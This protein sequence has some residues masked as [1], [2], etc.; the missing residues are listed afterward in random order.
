MESPFGISLRNDI[1]GS[2]GGEVFFA[3]DLDNLSEAIAAGGIDAEKT[4]YLIGIRTP[5]QQALAK[6]IDRILESEVIWD[7]FGIEKRRYTFAGHELIKL[8]SFVEP[9][10]MH[11]FGF[12]DGYFLFSPR[13]PTLE[14]AIKAY[15]SGKCLASTPGCAALRAAMPEKSNVS[16]FARTSV[17]CGELLAAYSEWLSGGFRSAA[18]AILPETHKLG[19]SMMSVA[20]RDEG[21]IIVARSP[22]GLGATMVSAARLKEA[23]LR[24]KVAAT[25]QAIDKAAA[26]IK[27]YYEAHK[28]FPARLR[29]LVPKYLPEEPADPLAS[30]AGMPLR[31]NPGPRTVQDRKTVYTK[32]YVLAANGPDRRPDFDVSEFDPD[33][34]PAKLKAAEGAALAEMKAALYQFR[35]E[36]YADERGVKDEGDIVHV[37]IAGR[38]DAGDDR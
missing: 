4:P 20:F 27:S 21:I 26:A 18:R 7:H 28:T 31:Y 3:I 33:T 1:F 24:R 11:G 6:A 37:H 2:I 29:S 34:W 22:M 19:D 10:I 17:L 8:S 30:Y 12:V 23:S 5:R 25:R 9:R 15:S 16:V 36:L 13:H 32:G 14:K 38:A 35:K